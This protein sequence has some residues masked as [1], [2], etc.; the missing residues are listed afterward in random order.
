MV[1][2]MSPFYT[3]MA[4]RK[5]LDLGSCANF[6]SRYD[7]LKVTALDLAPASET[8]LRCD[9]LALEVGPETSKALY[10]HSEVIEVISLPA[11][12]FQ[13]VV[14]ALLLSYIAD[15]L[16]RGRVIRKARQ[17]LD[18]TGL[19]I[20][21]DTIASVGRHWDAPAW[22]KQVEQHGFRLLRDPQMH[23]A[24]KRDAEMG[25]V[26]RA[27]CFSFVPIE[28][29]E[30]KA[31]PLVLLHDEKVGVDFKWPRKDFDFYKVSTLKAWLHKM[32]SEVSPQRPDGSSLVS[33]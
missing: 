10:R 28:V 8:V 15:P 14:L 13:V 9:C 6:F 27:S 19:L 31:L 17:L 21:A 16:D 11:K 20:V 3:C 12:S 29:E 23:F 2:I 30:T 5:L 4:S 18:S 1:I 26:H 24:K 22:V 7:F 33:I 32:V 25:V